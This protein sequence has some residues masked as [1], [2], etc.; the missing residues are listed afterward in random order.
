M[1]YVG[2]FVDWIK[3]EYIEYMLNTDG[4]A[5]P[6]G[7]QNPDSEEFRKAKEHGYDLSQTYWYIYEKD[8]FPFD[9]KL[10]FNSELSSLWWGIKMKPGNFMPVHRDPHT[11]ADNHSNVTRYWMAL[12]DWEPGHIFMY[13]DQVLVNYKKGDVYSYPDPQAIHCAC[14][15]GNNTRLSFHFSTYES[16][17]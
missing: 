9:I 13:E 2:N 10:P 17:Y 7:G 14:N 5:R 4:T 1:N 16:K 15:I 6:G 8:T 11:Y 12:Q 3:P